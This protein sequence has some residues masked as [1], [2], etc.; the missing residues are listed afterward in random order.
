[1]PFC[2]HRPG[3]N[4]EQS[5]TW[6]ELQT[7]YCSSITENDAGTENDSDPKFSERCKSGGS[8]LLAM[9]IRS[10]PLVFGIQTLDRLK[11]PAWRS[12][13]SLVI[14]HASWVLV[15]G[16]GWIRPSLIRQ[17]DR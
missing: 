15:D 8:V 12:V 7:L 1:M 5:I 17:R 11:Y 14:G 16:R 9:T 6:P 4:S 10:L 2:L 3:H 13:P